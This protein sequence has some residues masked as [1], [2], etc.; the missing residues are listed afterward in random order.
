MDF[1]FVPGTTDQELRQ[2]RLFERRVETKLITKGASTV[3]GFIKVLTTDAQ[4][5]R[6]IGDALIGAHASSEGYM[7]ISLYPG[8]AG[9]AKFESLEAAFPGTDKSIE[10]PA[11]VASDFVHFKGCNVGKAQ[12]FI[13][14]FRDALGGIVSVT[15]PRHFH[16]IFEQSDQGSYEYMDYEFS[17][18][19]ARKKKDVDTRDALLA[20]FRAAQF[21]LID[22]SPVPPDAWDTWVPQKVTKTV[23]QDRPI[24]LS[25]AVGTRSTIQVSHQFR[26]ERIPF[27]W[28]IDYPTPNDVPPKSQYEEKIRAHMQT[29]VPF[30]STYPVWERLGYSTF[31]AFLEGYVWTYKL[32]NKK[33]VTATGE[34]VEYTVV[35]PILT[36]D[37]I[38]FNFHPLKAKAASL[39][40]VVQLLESDAKYFG[41]SPLPP[42]PGP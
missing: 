9:G 34:R 26:V 13:D 41:K 24:A 30:D 35:V 1:G 12:K 15:A 22:G 3:Q 11:D 21:K 32:E 39:P 7:K 17:I 5:E 10:I 38:S 20:A 6:P 33:K 19:L 29:Q 25:Q 18:R 14:K 16:G 23:K 40:P 42:P 28:F 2:R 37:K 31:Q 27:P 8:H 36:D 4:I